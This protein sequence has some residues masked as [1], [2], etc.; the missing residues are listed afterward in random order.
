[1]KRS[2]KLEELDCADCASKMERDINKI[3]GVNKATIN[4][5]TSKITLDAAD[6]AFDAVL[7]EAQRICA[8]YESDCVIV[9]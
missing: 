1:M 7:D 6:E 4:F 9:R 3:D 8:G 2:F 5:M